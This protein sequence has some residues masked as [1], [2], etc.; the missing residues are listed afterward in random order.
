MNYVIT[1]LKSDVTKSSDRTSHK[2]H[3]IYITKTNR[4]ILLGWGGGK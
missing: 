2:A 4:L 3:R 1:N